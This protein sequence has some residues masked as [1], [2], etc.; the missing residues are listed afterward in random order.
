MSLSR[1]RHTRK[2][3]RR[4]SWEN[5]RIAS[6]SI[7]N[8]E[9]EEEKL[10]DATTMK[11]MEMNE[12]RLYCFRINIWYFLNRWYSTDISLISVS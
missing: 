3:W 7:L 2:K 8:A 10:C 12:W 1:M 11:R 6:S 9:E 4:K 5:K